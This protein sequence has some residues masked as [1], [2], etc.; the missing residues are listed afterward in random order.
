MEGGNLGVN[1][2]RSRSGQQRLW[3]GLGWLGGDLWNGGGRHV[4][5]VFVFL[6]FSYSIRSLL[7]V[8]FFMT[9]ER[10]T[11]VSGLKKRE[12]ERERKEGA[13]HTGGKKTATAGLGFFM[14]I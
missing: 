4:A 14:F 6:L 9:G 10:V 12:R 8:D 7:L 5:G 2:G 11:E 13:T 3:G 1:G